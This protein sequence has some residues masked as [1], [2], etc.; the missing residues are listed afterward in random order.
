MAKAHPGFT[1]SQLITTTANELRKANNDSGN[2][3]IKL[4]SC[5][6]ELAVTLGAEGETGIRFW[7]VNASAKVDA[8]TVSTI[9]LSFDPSEDNPI[10]APASTQGGGPRN[11]KPE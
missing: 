3:V 5:E 7:L 1:L 11:E 9:K 2:A 4:K 8:Q 6:L 10:Q